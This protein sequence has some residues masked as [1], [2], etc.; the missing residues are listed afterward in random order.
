MIVDY[1]RRGF[2]KSGPFLLGRNRYTRLAL[3]LA[4]RRNFPRNF[5]HVIDGARCDGRRGHW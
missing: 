5:T 2:R 4:V 3:S 1:A